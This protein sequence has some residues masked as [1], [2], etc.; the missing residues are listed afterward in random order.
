MHP[1]CRCHSGGCNSWVRQED[2]ARVA[3]DGLDGHATAEL[4]P[5]PLD[6][7]ENG[8][9]MVEPGLGREVARAVIGAVQQRAVGLE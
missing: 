2:G 6:V 4:R 5:E 1:S 3:A 8:P 7:A 9:R